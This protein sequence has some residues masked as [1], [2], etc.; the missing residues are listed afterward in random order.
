MTTGAPQLAQLFR[1]TD[2]VGGRQFLVDTG[3]QVSVLPPSAVTDREVVVPRAAPRLEA[4]NGTAIALSGAVTTTV[5]LG[6]TNYE[7]TFLVADVAL[8]I[9]G[10]D[11]LAHH[12]LLVDMRE[13]ALRDA[14]GVTCAVGA[15]A[16]VSSLGVRM[17]AAPDY[18][19]VLG[20]F[21]LVAATSPRLLPVRHHVTHHIVTRGPPRVGRPRRLPPDRLRIARQ[22]FD[23]LVEL[24]AARPSKS[25]WAS[26]LHMV[27]KKE[28]GQWRPCGDYRALN[29]VTEP[30]RYPVP[31]LQD[32][33][34]NIHGATVFSKLDLVRAY[35][36]IPVEP[37]DVPKTAIVTPF[38]LFEMPRMSFGLRNASQTFQR[39]MDEVM[40]G[41]SCC[42]VY[43]DDILVASPSHEQHKHHLRQV[44]ER[45]DRYGVTINKAKCV[46]GVDRISF[47]GHDVS[48]DGIAP[49]PEKVS[50]VE[51]FPKPVTQTQL[52]RL[53]GMVTYYH[54]FLPHAAAL[55]RPL[56][57]L[58]DQ[59]R[60]RSA[61]LEWTPAAEDAFHRVKTALSQ[62]TRLAHPTPGAALSL[63]VD[64]S[65]TGV[66]A[67]L[68][69]H[70]NGG[71]S[72]LAFFSRTLKPPETR[73]STFGRELLA[74]YAAV[75]HFRHSLEGRH[76]V[77]YTDHK[78][79]VSAIG[80]GSTSY[81]PRETRQLDYVCQFTTDVRHVPGS[82]NVV[83][84]A[85]S[86]TIAILRSPTP[87]LDDFDAL[88]E[89]Q[90][91]DRG[92]REFLDS[93]HGLQVRAVPLIS[94]R[95]LL[96]DESTGSTRPLIPAA[97]RRAYFNLMHNLS[98][99]GIRASQDLISRRVVWPGMQ[100]DVRDWARACIACQR[101]KVHRHVRAPVATWTPP[102]G[103]FE[104]VHI[105]LVG[106]LPPSNGNVHLLTCVDRFT[107]W[108]EA[109]PLPDIRAATV[110]SA[111]VSG[112]VA[113]FG[114]PARV[115]TDRG[116]QFES[117]LWQELSSILGCT[118]HRTTSYHP[119]S[120]GLVER[121]HRQLKG[122]L[123]AHS[124]SSWTRALPLVLLGIRSAL[125][126]DL[127]CTAAELVY[128]QR[129][130][131]AWRVSR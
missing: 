4:A 96:C 86:R 116:S 104:E 38:G 94:G 61:P 69:Q 80:S 11:F 32:F 71:W 81:S 34:A 10:A 108:V 59:K 82:D 58:L 70:T 113:R 85:L 17:C 7:W 33:T 9:L 111:F 84:D 92:L 124:S 117:Q 77:I 19:A 98:H 42:F 67:V 107:R 88:A 24:G 46:F 54:R 39:F 23:R 102:A 114:V 28:P 131:S 115:T 78:A 51:N 13:R 57:Q 31:Y 63:Q 122:A 44:L 6:R 52:R 43:L 41:L 118:R 73:Y 21:P 27:P 29:S 1:L 103:R 87:P 2:S 45:L 109:I 128:G 110:A 106:P 50:A 83:A 36:Q 68:Q 121:V 53:I 130:R 56:H 93:P 3:A 119:Q 74:V 89:A 35:H 12:R 127:G 99:P 105:D 112:W 18:T 95:T 49:L 16:G 64:A 22:E 123:R 90:Q 126:E 15:P 25:S 66:G 129:F 26:P 120:N 14:R 40:R 8:P 37:A 60:K 76:F 125:K 100:R 72:P 97:L 75:R 55:L 79:L 91:E 48:P 30:D 62:A 47:L 65:D 5:R 101:A 20:E